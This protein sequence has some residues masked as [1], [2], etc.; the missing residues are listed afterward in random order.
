M[1]H[2]SLRSAHSPNKTMARE[3]AG[4]SLTLCGIGLIVA[5]AVVFAGFT[6]AQVRTT[7]E[8]A[9][10]VV[11]QTYYSKEAAKLVRDARDTLGLAMDACSG[12]GL[13]H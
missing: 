4:L 6:H 8:L 11:E 7:A 5:V 10:T 12:Q 9:C 2:W 13:A 3:A 1:D